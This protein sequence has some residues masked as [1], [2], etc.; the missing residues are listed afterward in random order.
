MNTLK[1]VWEKFD[2]NMTASFLALSAQLN[3]IPDSI[4]Y[5]AVVFW[6][7]S[8]VLLAAL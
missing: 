5:L 3:K 8:M 2:T 7:V 1:Y 6:T 4:F